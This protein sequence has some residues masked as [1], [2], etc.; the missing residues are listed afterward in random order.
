M[1]T[2][3]V[4]LQGLFAACLLLCL[5][6]MG[7]MLALPSPRAIAASQARAPAAGHLAG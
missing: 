4:L 2:E 5:S 1:K 3:T 7:A 6:V